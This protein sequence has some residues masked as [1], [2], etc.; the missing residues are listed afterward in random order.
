LYWCADLPYPANNTT[1]EALTPEQ[2]KAKT[3]GYLRHQAFDFQCYRID[4]WGYY[5][6]TLRFYYS[7]AYAKETDTVKSRGAYIKD[8]YSSESSAY[9]DNG[10]S[11]D[12]WYVKQ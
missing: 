8:V 9:P 3:S 11:G 2:A 7:A 1:W 6:S 4:Y 12:Y 5:N 10:I